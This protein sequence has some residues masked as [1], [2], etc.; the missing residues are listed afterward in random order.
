MLRAGG[1]PV[2][3][4]YLKVDGMTLH[5]RTGGRGS[6][7][8]MLHPSPLSSAAVLPLAQE[9]EPHFAVY[10]F[11]TPGYGLSD[12]LPQPPDT[13]Q[14]YLSTFSA[15]LDALGLDRICLY[16]AATGAQ[17][18]IEFA[19]R[20][21]ERVAMM[22]IDSAGH[23]PADECEA[24]VRDYFPDLTPH[25]DGR[26]V[27]T[28]WQ[29]VRDLFV[30]FPWCDR[31]AERRID[32]DLPPAAVM[33]GMLLDYLRAGAG[34]HL[35]YRPA[36]Y[37]ERAERAQQV[38]VPSALVR[39]DSSIVLRITDALIDAGLP[40][41]YSVLRLGP[42]PA[43]R[44]GGIREHL[45]QHFRAA[46]APPPPTS[47][48]NAG[49]LERGFVDVPGGQL[50]LRRSTDGG[51]R[52][53]VW[54]HDAGASSA[55]LDPS[56]RAEAG[57]RPVIALD[58]PGHGETEIRAGD[59]GGQIDAMADTVLA[60][61]DSLGLDSVDIGGR[62]AG[63]VIALAASKRRPRALHLDVQ[64]VPD[65]AALAS[66]ALPNLTSMQDGTHLAAA[67]QFVRDASLWRP[68]AR[69]QRSGTLAGE[70]QLGIEVLQPR[71]VELMKAGDGYRT[72]LRAAAA[73]PR[74]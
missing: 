24:I 27:M 36:F 69:G 22:V 19:N 64:T 72:L 35:A 34:Y 39:W 32:R 12:P 28:L 70:P 20:Y 18:A 1:E 11:D 16:G 43:E 44:F 2:R 56:V 42:T 30:F 38:K 13:L 51:G 26:H 54:L 60:A 25:H 61:L 7:V 40:A 46:A 6:P 67:W 9:L 52:P 45:L 4:A 58:L 15:A 71:F 29:M 41:N 17:F 48:P 21:P 8:V 49:R 66:D 57:Q 62:G 53:R 63:A 74:G 68:E 47:P 65:A 55:L 10:A 23:I 50:H 59:P 31:R 37:N 5:Y 3:R 14:D 33:Q 73:Y